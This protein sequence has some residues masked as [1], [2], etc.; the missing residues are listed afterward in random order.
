MIIPNAEVI[1]ETLNAVSK[2][3]PKWIADQVKEL[4]ES[5]AYLKSGFTLEPSTSS[6]AFTAGYNLGLQVARTMIAQSA[7]IAVSSVN[8]NDVL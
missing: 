7:A 5:N 8:P 6:E 4:A 2:V 1:E 3:D